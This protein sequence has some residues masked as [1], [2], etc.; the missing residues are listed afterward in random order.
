MATS[1]SAVPSSQGSSLGRC[2][3]GKCVRCSCVVK[4]A[5]CHNCLPS[6]QGRCRNEAPSLTVTPTDDAEIASGGTT[7]QDPSPP[8]SSNSHEAVPA[9]SSTVLSGGTGD[10]HHVSVTTCIPLDPSL[11]LP[12]FCPS[13]PGTDSEYSSTIKAAYEQVVHWKPNLFYL[14]KENAASQSVLEL[15]RLFNSY[16]QSSSAEGIALTSAMLLPSLILQRP[17]KRSKPQDHIGCLE[18]R[19]ALWGTSTGVRQLLNEGK[20]VQRHLS[21]SHHD[22]KDGNRTSRFTDFI[23]K[24]KVKDALCC[25]SGDG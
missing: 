24:G 13:S 8:L 20:S 1:G 25:P 23:C 22:R 3:S 15:T 16:A 10:D 4:K 6:R 17:H 5:T 2:T 18:H 21:R 11:A 12:T 7:Q 14:P 9:A 19:L